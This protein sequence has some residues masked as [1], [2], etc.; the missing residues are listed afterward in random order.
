MGVKMLLSSSGCTSSTRLGVVGRKNGTKMGTSNTPSK[1]AGGLIQH[2]QFLVQRLLDIT[3][4][5]GKTISVL[6]P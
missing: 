5:I 6:L 1:G 3:H 2:C 4:R